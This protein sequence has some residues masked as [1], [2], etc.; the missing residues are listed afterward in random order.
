MSRVCFGVVILSFALSYVGLATA[1]GSA[2]QAGTPLIPHNNPQRAIPSQDTPQVPDEVD[3]D[4]FGRCNKPLGTCADLGVACLPGGQSADGTGKA[5]WCDGMGIRGECD[6]GWSSC[7]DLT[8]S[9]GCGREWS[10]TCL[11][12]GLVDENSIAWTGRWCGYTG[13]S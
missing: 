5:T 13:C 11:N 12:N 8:Q 2:P 1:S 10:G 7:T 6:W 3:P 9:A 4:W